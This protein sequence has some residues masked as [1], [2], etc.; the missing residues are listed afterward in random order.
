M[1]DANDL[2]GCKQATTLSKPFGNKTEQSVKVITHNCIKYWR[3]GPGSQSVNLMAAWK[4]QSGQIIV[5]NP[6]FKPFTQ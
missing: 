4:G 5:L 3:R 2:I 1:I 6:F